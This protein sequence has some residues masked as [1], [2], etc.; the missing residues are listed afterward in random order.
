METVAM[1]MI[2]MAKK[3][4]MM[5]MMLLFIIIIKIII[6][7]FLCAVSPAEEANCRVSLIKQL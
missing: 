1:N 7:L 5:M 4:K 6:L 2:K 3:K